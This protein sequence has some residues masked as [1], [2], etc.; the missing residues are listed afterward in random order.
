MTGNVQ[1][2][3]MLNAKLRVSAV[4][5]PN[6]ARRRNVLLSEPAPLSLLRIAQAA[7]EG[8]RQNIGRA[9]ARSY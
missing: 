5:N 4:L 3:S 7:A 1:R 9:V 2:H 6:Y 8:E